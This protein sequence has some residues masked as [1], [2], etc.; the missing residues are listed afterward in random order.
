MKEDIGIK[1]HLEH[2][3]RIETIDGL[4]CFTVNEVVEKR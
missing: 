3:Y 4:V 1:I 2:E